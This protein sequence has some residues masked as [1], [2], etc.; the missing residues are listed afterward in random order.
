M[1]LTCYYAHPVSNYGTPE[2][3]EALKTLRT[4]GLQVVN[5]NS[6]E[7]RERYAAESMQMFLDIVGACQSLAF[8]SFEDGT[9]GAGVASEIGAARAAGIPVFELPPLAQVALRTLSVEATRDKL[10][11][12]KQ[13][14]RPVV[15]THQLLPCTC[16]E[17]PLCPVHK[18]HFYS[19]G[20]IGEG[21]EMTGTEYRELGFVLY[22]RR[23]KD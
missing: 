13:G 3:R 2:E 16:C 5:P 23:S 6:P 22:G 20:C 11:A 4:L 1:K 21:E 14:W 12:L 19:C 9:I 10:E 18:T 7:Y 17:E 8:R 15:E